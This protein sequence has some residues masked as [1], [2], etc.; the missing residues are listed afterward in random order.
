MRNF[1]IP[2]ILQAGC[3][4]F[5]LS[6]CTSQG[7][8][9][10][11]SESQEADGTTSGEAAEGVVQIVDHPEDRKI[12]VLIDGDLFTSYIYPT[13]I[14]KPVLYP[15]ITKSGKTLTRG[16]PL[17]PRPGERVDHPHHVGL[18]FN[19]GDVNGLDFWNNS[20]AIPEDEKDHY[21]TI[22]HKEVKEISGNKLKVRMEWLAPSGEALLDENTTFTFAQKGNERSIIRETTLTARDKEVK[23]TDNKE[24]LI[25][26]RVTRALE[27]PSDG[28]AIFTDAEGNP[29][30]VK[31]LDNEGV[32]GDYLSSEKITG[33]DVWGTRGR[34]VQLHSSIDGE[35]V[36]ITIMDHPDNVGYPTYW[37][38]RGY[39]LFA[40]N[41]LGQKVF[42]EGKEEL[43]FALKPGE[44]VTFKYNVLIHSGPEM[45]AEDIEKEYQEFVK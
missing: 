4:L 39:G 20:E 36:S 35:P 44:S 22:V 11:G 3:L 23:F 32:N 37:H 19:Y 31:K 41:P 12:D 42:S 16:F 15:L 25:G 10:N 17:D 14:A 7:Q 45:T 6:A 26:V 33:D 1:K 29:T 9:N 43:N 18:W 8:K 21:G 27:L 24:G 28:P 34:W 30:E 5:A 40:A 38:A 13:D 2:A